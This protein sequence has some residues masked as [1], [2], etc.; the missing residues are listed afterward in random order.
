M[1]VCSFTI[2]RDVC[3]NLN[4]VGLIFV[5]MRA[6]ELDQGELATLYQQARGEKLKGKQLKAAMVEMDKDGGG[7]V[8][9]DEFEGWWKMNG[10]DLEAHRLLA[11]TVHTA[12][13]QLLLVRPLGLYA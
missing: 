5:V 12:D 6:G 13:V 2:W 3:V 10:G 11:I 7:T 8:S 1:R 4:A 9:F